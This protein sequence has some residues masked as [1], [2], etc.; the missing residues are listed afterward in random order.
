MRKNVGLVLTF[1]VLL[2]FSLSLVSFISAG[3]LQVTQEHPFL[4]NGSWMPAKNLHVGDILQTSDG[5]KVRITSIEDI[6]SEKPFFVYNFE[7]TFGI[8]NYIVNGGD[9]IGVVVHNSNANVNPP[10]RYS[11]SY[12]ERIIATEDPKYAVSPTYKS[13]MVSAIDENVI[14]L[15][16]GSQQETLLETIDDRLAVAETTILENGKKDVDL[17]EALNTGKKIVQGTGSSTTS[18]SPSFVTGKYAYLDSKLNSNFMKSGNPNLREFDTTADGPDALFTA[19]FKDYNANPKNKAKIVNVLSV[20]EK[21]YDIP[22]S[23]QKF[24]YQ[25]YKV[26]YGAGSEGN[27]IVHG[28]PAAKQAVLNHLY[29]L[30]DKVLKTQNYEERVKLIAQYEWWFFNSNPTIRGG[31]SIGDIMSLSMQIKIGMPIRKV[32]YHKDFEALSMTL[33][34]YTKFVINEFKINVNNVPLP[35]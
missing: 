31:A 1:V 34:D 5:G 21:S 22:E 32:Y 10:R 19:F 16:P 28:Q 35:P 9:G 33:E 29:N 30:G 23:T 14:N 15:K 4:I 8:N 12:L 2:F 18:F 24:I 3:Q 13:R 25:V 26:R 7:D 17:I 6:I 27:W 20:Y 11:D